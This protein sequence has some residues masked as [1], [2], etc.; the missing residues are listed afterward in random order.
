MVKISVPFNAILDAFFPP[1]CI[2]L[3]KHLRASI[4]RELLN[5]DV[6][7]KAL[8]YARAL[9]ASRPHPRSIIP[10][11]YERKTVL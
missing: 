8:G 10:V 7:A 4:V 5:E 1:I 6:P 3:L 11:L 9:L 2:Y